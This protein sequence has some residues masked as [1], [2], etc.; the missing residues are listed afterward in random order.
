M[1]LSQGILD[2]MINPWY[3]FTWR[4][5]TGRNFFLLC[6]HDASTEMGSNEIVFHDNKDATIT[7]AMFIGWSVFSNYGVVCRKNL[8][9]TNTLKK[10]LFGTYQDV[11]FVTIKTNG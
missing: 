3:F 9:I 8:A 7:F 5:H 11:G 1:F 6:F 2:F 4:N 10:P